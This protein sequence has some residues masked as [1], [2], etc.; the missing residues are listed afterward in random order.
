MDT[1]KAAK[2]AS[3]TRATSP[4]F[5]GVAY[6]EQC[7]R[8]HHPAKLN[9]IQ[10]WKDE[11]VNDYHNHVTWRIRLP[12]LD[13]VWIKDWS[14]QP[15]PNRVVS[16]QTNRFISCGHSFHV[17]WKVRH[18]C[19][20]YLETCHSLSCSENAEDILTNKGGI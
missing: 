16:Y 10:I 12:L 8:N 15:W 19:D 7:H 14:G 13:N 2:G 4:L 20:H 5:T 18:A 1:S 17:V 9:V 6:K 11:G 3:E